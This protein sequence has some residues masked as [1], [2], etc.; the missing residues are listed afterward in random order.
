VVVD[1]DVD[2]V[3]ADLGL[4][5][6]G[7]ALADDAALVDDRDPVGELVGLLEV[8]GG[9]ED[10]RPVAGAQLADAVPD[11]H[12]GR[13]VQA[14]GRLVQEQHPGPVQ[15]GRGE[16]QAAL[17]AARVGLDA[18]VD[19]LVQADQL[20]HLADLLGQDRAAQPVQASLQAEQLP[21]GLLGVE[22]GLL[23]GH[24]D[25]P[26][27]LGRLT[28]HVVPEDRARAAGGLQQGGEH[29]DD[30]RLAGPVGAE[31]PVDLGLVDV[32]ADAADGLDVAEAAHEIK[33][34]DRGGHAPE[35]TGG[36]RQRHRCPGSPSGGATGHCQRSSRAPRTR[37]RL[38]RRRP[39]PARGQLTLHQG[40]RTVGQRRDSLEG[41]PAAARLQNCA[42]V[43]PEH[44][45]LTRIG[46]GHVDLLVR[47]PPPQAGTAG[48]R[49]SP[50]L[51]LHAFFK[52]SRRP[53]SG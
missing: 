13:R 21:A 43:G 2:H 41:H 11:Q 29:A 9:Q 16:V 45:R 1:R 19:R 38:G 25:Q 10:R 6:G 39:A 17:H 22:A 28:H 23:E 37:R 15:Q 33:G 27:H 20:G 30:G 7:G 14:G 51:Q 12:P 53:V 8:L 48:H 4:E 49:A 32:E 50:T 40:E 24:A 47:G 42:L 36:P 18:A 52:S 35:C 44:D 26:A 34:L 5:L 46:I 31:E 3:R